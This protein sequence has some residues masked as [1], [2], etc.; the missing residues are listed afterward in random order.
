MKVL[1][2]E[3]KKDMLKLFLYIGVMSEISKILS[4]YEKALAHSQ[5]R[6]EKLYKDKA[7]NVEGF[8]SAFLKG[9]IRRHPSSR[10]DAAAKLQALLKK[11]TVSFVAIDGHPYKEQMSDYAIFFAAAYGI[12]GEISLNPDPR[13]VYKTRGL[14]SDISIVAYV[15]I[16]MAEMG[17]VE[18]AGV[19]SP[20]TSP[21]AEK[22]SGLATQA[23]FATS[24]QDRIDLGSLHVKL[25]TLAEIY[26][27]FKEANSKDAPDFILW[28]QSMSLQYQWLM[29]RIET[30]PMIINNYELQS[31]TSAF[32][33]RRLQK[34]DAY[35]A[36]T[37]PYNKTLDVPGAVEGGGV[38]ALQRRFTYRLFETASHELTIDDLANDTKSDKDTT[39]RVVDNFLVKNGVATHSGDSVKLTSDAKTSWE[40][41]VELYQNFCHKLFD[42]KDDSVLLYEVETMDGML[43][44]RRERWLSPNDLDFLMSI[45]LRRTMELC[46]EKGKR[47]VGVVKD[48]YQRYF[49]RNYLGVMAHL[50]RYRYKPVPLP[51]TDRMTL[52]LLSEYDDT[53]SAPWSTVDYD[54]AYVTLHM[55]T[56]DG[57]TFSLQGGPNNTVAPER[58][59]AKS[60]AQ[61]Y[62]DRKRRPTLT[63]HV[64]FVDR[65]LDP[66]LD[67][68][69]TSRY[70]VSSPAFGT[71][72]PFGDFLAADSNPAQ[73]M[74]MSLLF[75]MCRNRYPEVIGYPEPLHVADW[76]AKSFSDRWAQRM[77]KSSGT[78]L[79]AQPLSRTFREVRD[80]SG[81]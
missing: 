34:S 37:H 70:D 45:G 71:V 29:H 2:F 12:P 57:K 77:I 31:P 58:L 35:V 22:A 5:D 80:Q 26:L 66:A 67:A 64:L 1:V 36:L 7:S 44:I 47:F 3:R 17:D 6:Y 4:S 76:A 20:G 61:F 33:G 15:P 68:K 38:F 60:L 46:W 53:L 49:T 8:Y 48:S 19:S 78:K 72:K 63:S 59:F 30:V 62:I 50:G 11:D 16:P 14:S 42:K 32:N 13:L 43:R 73:E 21:E 75:L 55:Y 9:L 56:E 39:A 10:S 18:Q 81:R 24:D 74:V 27:A 40:F 69:P 54:S 51:W 52:E 65:L 79:K 41:V 23:N 28:D 25:M